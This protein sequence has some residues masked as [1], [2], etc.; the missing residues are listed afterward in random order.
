MTYQGPPPPPPLTAQ[1]IVQGPLMV[2]AAVILSALLGL[3]GADRL[4]PA[5]L[6]FIAALSWYQQTKRRNTARGLLAPGLIGTVLT[7]AMLTYL[8]YGAGTVFADQTY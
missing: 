5:P 4:Y 1:D 6:A 7:V 2:A 3:F 8:A